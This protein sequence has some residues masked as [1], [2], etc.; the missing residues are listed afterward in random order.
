MIE[1]KISSVQLTSVD[2]SSQTVSRSGRRYSRSLMR[3]YW[4]VSVTWVKMK[5]REAQALYAKLVS[6]Q[7]MHGES[8]LSL[9]LVGEHPALSGTIAVDGVAMAG[10]SKI[11]ING[12]EGAFSVGGVFNFSGHNK[13]YMVVEHQGGLLTFAPPLRKAVNN[14]TI[15]YAAPTIKLHRTKEDMGWK[16]DRVNSQL[17]DEFEEVLE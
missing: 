11:T 7:G 4:R 3:Q 16:Q 6:M 15:N 2:P 10:E 13:L 1:S 5:N 8:V 14:D 12:F 17:T 9:P